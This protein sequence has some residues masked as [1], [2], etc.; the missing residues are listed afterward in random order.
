MAG[1]ADVHD[2]DFFGSLQN[3][4]NQ[5][6]MTVNILYGGKYHHGVIRGEMRAVVLEAIVDALAEIGGEQ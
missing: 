5:G 4:S 3:Y 1:Q 6:A 2:L